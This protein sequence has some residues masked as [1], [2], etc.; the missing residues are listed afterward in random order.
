MM[1]RVE[2]PSGELVNLDKLVSITDQT[3]S[4]I[5]AY[6]AVP[7]YELGEDRTGGTDL[8]RRTYYR[9]DARAIVAEIRRLME[10]QP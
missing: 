10:T 5:T 9:D 2:L 8:L 6:L 1:H 4:D 3:P 7:N